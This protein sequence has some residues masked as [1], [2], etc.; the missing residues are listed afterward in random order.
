[1]TLGDKIRKFRQLKD[2]SQESMAIALGLSVTGYAKIER[3][4]TNVTV[5][6]LE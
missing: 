1:M 2:Y 5:S 3:N 4:E 6:R